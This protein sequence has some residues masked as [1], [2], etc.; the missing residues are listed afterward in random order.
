[1]SLLGLKINLYPPIL[2]ELGN[3]T[4]NDY[5]EENEVERSLAL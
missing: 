5:S 4:V 2:R 1:M 3:L